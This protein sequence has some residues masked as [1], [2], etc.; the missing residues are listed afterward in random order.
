MRR[1]VTLPHFWSAL[2]L[3][4]LGVSAAGGFSIAQLALLVLA[5]LQHIEPWCTCVSAHML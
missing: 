3:H 2:G 1:R 5:V 4:A